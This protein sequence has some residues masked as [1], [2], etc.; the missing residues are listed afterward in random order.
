MNNKY[1][2]TQ[3]QSILKSFANGKSVSTIVDSTGIPRSTIYAW[4][5]I[6]REKENRKDIS[7]K[8]FRVLENK[9]KR[10]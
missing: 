8:N 5:K 7:L 4:I 2:E 9:V 10:L 1:T 3:K 6:S